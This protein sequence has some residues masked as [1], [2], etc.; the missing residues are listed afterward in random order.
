MTNP[1]TAVRE[2]LDFYARHH[3][4]LNTTAPNFAREALKHLEALPQDNGWRA[5]S[6]VE[7]AASRVLI[8]DGSWVTS[9]FIGYTDGYNPT[10]YADDLDE[11][12]QEL[13][14]TPTHWQPLPAAPGE[15]APE[16]QMQHPIPLTPQQALDVLNLDA[17]SNV[18]YSMPAQPTPEPLVEDGLKFIK[19]AHKWLTSE[20]HLYRTGNHFDKAGYLVQRVEYAIEDLDKALATVSRK[21]GA[22]HA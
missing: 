13:P 21:E 9:A 10:Y 14:I 12:E 8:T 19:S 5:I 3:H 4:C 22:D 15:P 18:H 11:Y 16:L 17:P 7:K 2:A 1:L 6:T 20:L